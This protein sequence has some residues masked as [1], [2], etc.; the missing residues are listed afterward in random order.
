MNNDKL[1]KLKYTRSGHKAYV[2][3]LMGEKEQANRNPAYYIEL[4]EEKVQVIAKLT[5][6]LTEQMDQEA[7]VIKEIVENSDYLSGVR[8]YI[9]S[10]KD[11]LPEKP[12]CISDVASNTNIT[13]LSL[14]K[15]DIKLFNGNI[16]D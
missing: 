8:L 2:T 4:L 9:N 6:D 5:E 3:K 1:K 11:V 14:P 16:A 10:L 7:D 13:H 15:I 12:K